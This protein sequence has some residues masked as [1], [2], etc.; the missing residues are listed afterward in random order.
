MKETLSYLGPDVEIEGTIRCAD[1]IRIDGSFWGNIEGKDKITLGI[2]AKI[3]GTVRAETLIINGK[4]EG[5]LITSGTIAVLPQGNIKGKIFN[6]A[7][8]L[9]IAEG[10]VFQGDLAIDP[11]ELSPLE[12]S[13]SPAKTLP[14]PK[15]NTEKKI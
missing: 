13:N 11:Q 1:A 15:G 7:G 14:P 9:T 12:K 5:E 2:S 10:G 4:V 6:P 3:H 8:G